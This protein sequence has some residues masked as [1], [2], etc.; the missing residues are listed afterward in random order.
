MRLN[1][2][3]TF[4]G[5]EPHVLRKVGKDYR[6]MLGAHIEVK[7]KEILHQQLCTEYR[8]KLDDMPDI[9]P[10]EELVSIVDSMRGI[11]YK[12]VLAEMEDAVTSKDVQLHKDR[13]TRVQSLLV[14]AEE[15]QHS[16][17]KDLFTQKLPKD[18]RFR[19]TRAD[20]TLD[21]LTRDFAHV[22]NCWVDKTDLNSQ[23][24]ECELTNI[25]RRVDWHLKDIAAGGCVL[26]FG[27]KRTARGYAPVVQARSYI[28]PTKR[29]DV[30]FLDTI[31]GGVTAWCSSDDWTRH[32]RGAELL[33]TI[34][35]TSYVA[36]EIGLAGVAAGEREVQEIASAIGFKEQKLFDEENYREE[37]YRRKI[38]IPA[39]DGWDG[40]YAYK[41]PDGTK[42]PVLGAD[43]LLPVTEEDL[44]MRAQRI[45]DLVSRYSKLRK[46]Q[47]KARDI[48]T[49]IDSLAALNQHTYDSDRVRERISYVR[50]K[51][52]A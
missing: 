52:V 9:I 18:Y 12:L 17:I 37:K 33:Y 46:N 42:K 50:Q 3:S 41:L 40:P 23:F 7:P 29:G 21:A 19:I 45:L 25:L 15:F 27:E 49:Y 28:S 43:D 34:A 11:S 1:A 8:A 13:R 6:R 36:R 44:V 30:L 51:L 39:S 38:G 47:T 5:K 48:G 20:C 22:N 4:F 35:A 24:R 31:E 16:C 26:I 14:K 32:K 10:H 2:I